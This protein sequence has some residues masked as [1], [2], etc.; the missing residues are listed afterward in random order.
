MRRRIT[1]PLSLDGSVDDYLNMTNVKRVMNIFP[2]SEWTTVFTMANEI[3]TYE[4]FLKGVAKFPAFCN[5]TN[6]GSDWSLEDTCKRE[7]STLFAHWGQETGARSGD[8]STWWTQAL[9][10]IEEIS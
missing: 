5:E 4:N 2:E 3:Y 1:S 9:Y 10:Y 8:E 7:L 6:L